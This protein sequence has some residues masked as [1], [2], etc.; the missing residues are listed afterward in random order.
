MSIASDEGS[1][2]P[3]I[4]EPTAAEET[5]LASEVS[6]PLSHDLRVMALIG[7]AHG[8]SHFFQLVL[9]PLFPFL[10]AEFEVSYTE[11]GFLMTTFFIS[12]GIGQPF[13]GFVVDRI[14]ARRVMLAGLGLYTLAIFALSLAPSYWV[15]FPLLAIAGVGNC[16]FHPADYTLLNANVRTRYLGRA[17]G[18]HTLGG[19]LGWAIAPIYMLVLA[20]AF[21]WRAALAGAAALGAVVWLVVWW[22]RGALHAEPR[23]SN[24][25][26]GLRANVDM[27]AQTSI[28]LC[29][30]YFMLLAAALIAVQNFLPALLDSMY[31]TPT[32]LAGVVLTGFLLGAASGV[33]CGGFLADHSPQHAG[34]IIAGLVVSGLLLLS[35]AHIN[36]GST[37]LIATLAG[38]GFFS[39][40]TTPSRDLLV[41]A[42][43]PPGATGRVFGIVYSGLDVGSALAPISVGLMLDHGHPRWALWAVAAFILAAVFTVSGI[44]GSLAGLRRT[45]RH[46]A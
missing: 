28:V 5:P 29:F 31:A 43:T 11:L 6:R 9:P 39:G 41:R 20:Q 27:L 3:S 44:K 10:I 37:L 1:P 19:N 21:G 32:V 24:P 2:N 13:A 25:T 33:V 14:G 23:T 36:F 12:S 8:T 22:H 18:V 7:V 4:S 40:V 38:A 46:S 34:I 35:V 17:F 30:A 15:L 16:V 26:V 45:S 42:A